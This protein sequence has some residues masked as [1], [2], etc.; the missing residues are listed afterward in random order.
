M[1]SD[2]EVKIRRLF[3]VKAEDTDFLA[4]GTLHAEELPAGFLSRLGPAVL[5]QLYRF[6][7]RQHYVYAATIDG[8]LVGFISGAGDSKG[9][10]LQFLLSAPYGT[11]LRVGLELLKPSSLMRAFSLWA[12]LSQKPPPGVPAAELLSLAT[13]RTFTK[14]GIGK[15]LVRALEEAFANEK[16]TRYKIAS[17]ETQVEAIRFYTNLGGQRAGIIELSGIKTYV[18]VMNVSR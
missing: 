6:L 10:N 1:A 17:A 9:I 13:A 5:A 2:S 8:Q 7:A 3:G 18:F 4:I 14:R 12:Y 16:I 11:L 15:K